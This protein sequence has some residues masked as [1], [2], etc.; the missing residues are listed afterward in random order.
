MSGNSPITPAGFARLKDELQNLKSV[1]R[2]KIISEVAAAREHGDLKENAEYH[3][4]REKHA[5]IEA[6]I[7]WLEGHLGRCEV[8]DPSKLGGDRVTFGATVRL[9]NADTGDEVTY[10]IVGPMEAENDKG[11]ISLE[12]PLARQLIGRRVGDEVQVRSPGGTRTYEVL[13]IS[14]G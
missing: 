13:D 2:P 7:Q 12:S 1:E 14:F 9:A 6:R 5:F 3:A 11:S 4:A 10:S 8:I